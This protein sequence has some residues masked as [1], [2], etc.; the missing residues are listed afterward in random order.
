MRNG[1]A[2]VDLD[3]T[4]PLTSLT[5]FEHY[6]DADVL[7]RL[8]ER[9]LGFVRA[10]IERGSLAVDVGLREF[11]AR[12]ARATGVVLA[13]RAIASGRPPRWPD[14]GALIQSTVPP[15]P[16]G[17]LVSVAVCASG[18]SPYLRRC[19]D[20]IMALDYRPLDVL[21]VDG[22]SASHV[23]AA[24]RA[25]YPG[26][27]YVRAAG[28]GVEAA[29]EVALAESRGDI[30]AFT[31][32]D[33]VVDRHWIS[34]VVRAFLVDPEVMVVAGVVVPHVLPAGGQRLSARPASE[35][36]RRRRYR[37]VIGRRRVAAGSFGASTNLAVWRDAFADPSAPEAI[38]TVLY[39]PSAMVRCDS[40]NGAATRTLSS[41]VEEWLGEARRAIRTATVESRRQIELADPMR[42]IS[43]AKT[44]D[45]LRVT[46]LWEGARLGEVSID[47]HGAVISAAWL[48]D[49]IAQELT[50]EVL[51]A[52]IGLGDAVLFSTV[53]STMARALM[54]A[55][56]ASR[57]ERRRR[58]SE[59]A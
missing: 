11:L 12:H 27:R 15:A 3:V 2:V 28:S 25:E 56:E 40:V 37:A 58:T 26:V 57:R 30:L 36:I 33:A 53:T 29:R 10:P 22:G 45:R 41:C 55:I 34:A 17:P 6:T 1:T 43:D 14:A 59:A 21:V 35:L 4:Q 32:E 46:V 44:D 50:T 42:A 7:C 49:V 47:H 13:E 8:R 31:S 54:P 39:E 5:G 48:T 23:P 51:D 52:H 24:L 18:R 20:A 16:S 19:L 38:H 9:P